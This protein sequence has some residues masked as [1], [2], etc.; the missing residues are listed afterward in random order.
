[1]YIGNAEKKGVN[2]G[3]NIGNFMKVNTNETERHRF[4]SEQ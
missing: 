3:Y 4:F 1:M 2:E